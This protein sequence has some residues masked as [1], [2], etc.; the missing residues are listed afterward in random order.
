[1]I[2]CVH[3][4]ALVSCAVRS[5]LFSAVYPDLPRNHFAM[6]ASQHTVR[7][8]VG[9]SLVVQMTGTREYVMT[10]TLDALKDNG[11]TDNLC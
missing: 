3:L 7:S 9:F 1:M 6:Q 2:S 8:V 5:A 4:L 11:V 10:S